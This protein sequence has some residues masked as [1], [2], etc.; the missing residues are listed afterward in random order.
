MTTFSNTKLG[1]E[2]EWVTKIYLLN[3]VNSCKKQVVCHVS[4]RIK[5]INFVLNI[6]DSLVFIYSLH[7]QFVIYL[8]F[9]DYEKDML[10]EEFFPFLFWEKG[11]FDAVLDWICKNRFTLT[12]PKWGRPKEM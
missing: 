12:N 7:F 4:L 6:L 3:I 8:Q 5:V 10:V 9:K 1:C 2:N 11:Y